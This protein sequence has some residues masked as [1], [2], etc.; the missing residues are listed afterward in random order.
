MLKEQ[1]GF[2]GSKDSF[3]EAHRTRKF[4]VQQ[5]DAPAARFGQ[6]GGLGCVAAGDRHR[7][8][9]YKE[10]ETGATGFVGGFM[11]ASSE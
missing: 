11:T 1:T 8:P 3:T 5:S 2:M 4:R 10:D 9:Q 6:V 7:W